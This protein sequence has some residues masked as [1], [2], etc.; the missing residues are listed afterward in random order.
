MGSLCQ[1]VRSFAYAI[2][3]SVPAKCDNRSAA[4]VI[5]YDAARDARGRELDE[6]LAQMV[7]DVI[8][9]RANAAVLWIGVPG[10][11]RRG[12]WLNVLDCDAVGFCL[13][14]DEVWND[15]HDGLGAEVAEN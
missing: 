11:M 1:S 5:G 4:F 9:E 13:A 8:A 3:P 15:V 14:H 7:G 10:E 6:L 12:L 2:A